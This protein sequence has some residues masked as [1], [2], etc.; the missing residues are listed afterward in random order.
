METISVIASFLPPQLGNFKSV[1]KLSV[2]NG[3]QLLEVRCVGESTQ[4]GT[5]KQLIGE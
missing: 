4:S 2:A 5:R 1:V 3:L